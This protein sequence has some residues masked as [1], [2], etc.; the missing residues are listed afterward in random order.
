MTAEPQDKWV[1]ISVII[2][3]SLFLKSKITELLSQ[4]VD[5][6]ASRVY[7]TQTPG[8]FLSACLRT[9]LGLPQMILGHNCHQNSGF[10]FLARKGVEKKA[11]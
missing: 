11:A 8:L 9:V 7:T 3:S 4:T 10:W 6:N 1:E 5:P 2:G